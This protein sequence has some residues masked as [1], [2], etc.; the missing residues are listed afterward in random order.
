MSLS[1]PRIYIQL[2]VTV[3]LHLSLS[4]SQGEH[5]VGEVLNILKDEFH[6]SMALTGE[7]VQ[8]FS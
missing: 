4:L 3:F 6:T 8:L 2:M 1:T 5:G 7:C